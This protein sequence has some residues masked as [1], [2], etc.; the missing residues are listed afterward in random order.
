MGQLFDADKQL[1]SSFTSQVYLDRDGFIWVATRN[2]LN[3][4]DGYQFDIIKKEWAPD[5]GSN[6]VNCMTQDNDGLFYI[7]MY[8][9]LQTYD[10]NHFQNVEVKGVHGDVFTCY[11][12]C[13]LLKKNGEVFAGTSGH[14]LL[15]VIDRSHAEQVGGV[16]KD[17]HTV[18]D[19]M[20]DHMG[21]IWLVTAH[22]GLLE[23]NWKD[24]RRY[25]S[26]DEERSTM[27]RLCC[28]Q[29]GNVY[30]GT[31]N[32]VYVRSS[33]GSGFRHLDVTGSR[34]VSS[35]LCRRDGRMMIGYDG[36][37]VAI[38]NPKTGTIEDNPYYSR[39]VN[40]SK[41]KVYSMVEDGSGNI[42]LGL[43]QKGIYMQPGDVMGFHYLGYKLG[44]RNIIGEAC[45]ISTM[46]DSKIFSNLCTGM[47]VNTRL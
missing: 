46:V 20:E 23:Y 32:G 7:G 19:L 16:L 40:L 42:W 44:Q 29:D 14:G 18:N 45:V 47:N 2:G 10:G 22:E 39:E 43:L 1:S 4:Y 8:G 36:E 6:Y 24:I 35:M 3:R 11:V 17:V 26:S 27:H 30:V 38:Y 21:H 33:D 15:K 31:S 12:T 37:G 25:F 41:S 13:F 5:M 34:H 28:D 9:A